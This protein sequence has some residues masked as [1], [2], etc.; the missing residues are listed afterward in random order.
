[1]IRAVLREV[2]V[3]RHGDHGNYVSEQT[4]ESFVGKRVSS[5]FSNYST[6]GASLSSIQG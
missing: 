6:D 2:R 4:K 3:Y 1:M 5:T